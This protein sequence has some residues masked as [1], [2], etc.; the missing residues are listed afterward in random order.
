MKPFHLLIELL[1]AAGRL[2]ATWYGQS[3]LTP[4]GTR[5]W[6]L[7][8]GA[9]MGGLPATFSIDLL[10]LLEEVTAD[11]W[12]DEHAFAQAAELL[13]LRDLLAPADF[14]ALAT[15]LFD[16]LWQEAQLNLDFG[17]EKGLPS[18]AW[19]DPDRRLVRVW[20]ATNRQPQ[21][22]ANIGQGFDPAQSAAALTYGL[23]HVFI[24]ESHRPG[25]IGSPWWRRWIRLAADDRLALRSI[26]GLAPDHF[27]ATLA[28]KVQ[29][30]WAPG[31]RNLFLFIH[32]YNV[33]FGEA[34]IRAAQIGYDLKVPGEMA[35]FSWPSRGETADY[36]A[37][38]ATI[39]A[40]YPYLAGFLHELTTRSQA[41]RVHIFVHSMGNRG[42]LSALE[43][44]VA[45]G[46]PNLQLGQLFF[47]APDEDVRTF[48][49]KV[50]R[51]PHQAENRTLLLSPKDRAVAASKW[52]H[53]ADRV[54]ISPPV[55]VIPGIDT[56]EV[57]G[58]GLLDLGHGYF[59]EAAPIIDD[60]SAAIRTRQKASERKGLQ[61]IADY[62][63]IDIRTP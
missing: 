37:D 18:Q 46:L 6:P 39:G 41:E 29:S 52:L 2:R 19:S 34:A 7:A 54:G 17:L 15:I 38:E 3:A 26:E 57:R 8:P 47:C 42:L 59:A 5:A 49:D 20:F 61:R 12:A 23:C 24:P 36:F 31:E 27:W 28:D 55:T 14:M 50:T 22:P 30:W 13:P 51:F 62:Y 33:G 35:F 16:L 53:K 21:D 63:G 45:D 25:S 32:G 11:V 56:I 43:R 40:T 1:L 44:L 58:F 60:L 9:L 4:V 48:C 10:P